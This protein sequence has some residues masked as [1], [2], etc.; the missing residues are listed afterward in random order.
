MKRDN[1]IGTDE[2][3]SYGMLDIGRRSN[4]SCVLVGSS[5]MHSQTI[6]LRIK[7]AVR[8]RNYNEDRFF[9]RDEL[10]EIEL[11]PVQFAEAITAMN[12]SGVPCTIRWIRGEGDMPRPVLD[13]E[14][15]RI[16]EEFKGDVELVAKSLDAVYAYAESLM[17]KPSVSKADRKE[18]LG[19]IRQVRQ[20]IKCDLPFIAE[21]FNET[22]EKTVA[23]GKG[24]FEAYVLHRAL[25]LGN[26]TMVDN[27]IG[28]EPEP[29]RLALDG[30]T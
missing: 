14:R 12:T 16:A 30:E 3:P 2:H 21:Q 10:I 8:N 25:A 13:H 29:P 11:S 22:V 18:L 19:M 28:V 15:T 27:Q 5:I 20:D 17:D 24:E 26:P 4:T 7:R 23:Q 1:Y 6:A 9:S